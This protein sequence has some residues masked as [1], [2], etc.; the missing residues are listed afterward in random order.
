MWNMFMSKLGCSERRGNSVPNIQVQIQKPSSPRPALRP[1]L[2][3]CA[4][5]VHVSL[6]PG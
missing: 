3:T 4:S 2:Q 6:N 5:R 1:L